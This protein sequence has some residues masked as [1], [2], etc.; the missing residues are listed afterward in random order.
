MRYDRSHSDALGS[1]IA[2]KIR[3]TLR[4]RQIDLRTHTRYQLVGESRIPVRLEWTSQ[5]E[6]QVCDA[7][8]VDLSAAG[9]RLRLANPIELHEAVQV[10]LNVKELGLDFRCVSD[11]CWVRPEEQGWSVGCEFYSDL[12]DR[13]LTKLARGGYLERRT[14]ERF[15]VKLQATLREE[16]NASRS[17]QVTIDNYSSGGFR[18]NSAAA[19]AVGQRVLLNIRDSKGNRVTI[20][21][22]AL[23]QVGTVEGH[24]VGCC[25]LN[26]DGFDRLTSIA[27]RK[28]RVQPIKQKKRS[29][30]MATVSWVA[31]LTM[32]FVLS[33]KEHFLASLRSLWRLLH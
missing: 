25:F 33:Q 30:P 5:D 17:H 2:R 26:G 15:Q 6:S 21:A 10:R 13:I 24:A 29:M 20:P 18:F 7:E 4:L 11:V 14:D 19:I 9:A 32:V 31:L 12:P 23:W 8:L 3:M 1:E 27:G 22:R 28:K 16:L